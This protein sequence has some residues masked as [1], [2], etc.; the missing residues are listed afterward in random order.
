MCCIHYYYI[1]LRNS[2]KIHFDLK[3]RLIIHRGFKCVKAFSSQT[4]QAQ[5]RKLEQTLVKLLETTLPALRERLF[6]MYLAYYGPISGANDI[7]KSLLT[8][9]PSENVRRAVEE[10]ID[11]AEFWDQPELEEE[12]TAE[13]DNLG[14]LLEQLEAVA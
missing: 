1:A 13:I 5:S 11:D 3:S 2:W 12:E 10:L 6:D 8:V 14:G 9:I 4:D 7:K